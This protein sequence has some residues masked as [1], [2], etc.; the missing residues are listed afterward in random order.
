ME[1]PATEISEPSAATAPEAKPRWGGGRPLLVAWALTRTVSLLQ[2]RLLGLDIHGDV[3]YYWES[4]TRIAVTGPGGLMPEYPAPMLWF[5][6]LLHSALGGHRI[7]FLAAFAGTMLLLDGLFTWGLHRLGGRDGRRA[8]GFW[9]LFLWLLGPVVWFRFDLI[10][11]VLS[12]AG[13]L[14]ALQRF[15]AGAGSTL[16]A[17]AASK[18]VPAILWPALLADTGGLTPAGLRRRRIGI[19]AEFLS[20]GIVLAVLSWLY[21]GWDRLLSPLAWQSD[22]GLQIESIWATPLMLGRWLEPGRFIVRLSEFNSFEIYGSGRREAL[23]A[24]DASMIAGFILVALAYGHWFHRRQASPFPGQLAALL[25]VTTL[26]ATNKTLSPQYLL[27]LGGPMAA[28]LIA[29]GLLEPGRA[30]RRNRRLALQLAGALL[31]LGALTSLVFPYGYSGLF[32]R[33]GLTPAATMV[34]IARN[35]GLIAWLFWLAILVFR[36]RPRIS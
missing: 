10:P 2:W 32:M 7:G 4:M 28:L 30:R 13:L 17:G 35:A 26:I 34:L 18:L 33:N 3:S 25:A 6:G 14:L 21:A 24:A 9:I 36:G 8:S 15:P 19:T 16:A 1:T 20:A 31:L 12:G 29:G 23:A 11:A 22:R 5:F 27:W